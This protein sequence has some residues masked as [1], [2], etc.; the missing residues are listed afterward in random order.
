MLLQSPEQVHGAIMLSLIVSSILFGIITVQLILYVDHYADDKRTIKAVVTTSWLL[1]GLQVALIACSLYT[2]IPAPPG[3]PWVIIY[4]PWWA[5]QVWNTLSVYR[6]IGSRA[7]LLYLEDLSVES[8]D[9]CVGDPGH[10]DPA[11]TRHDPGP[12][13]IPMILLMDESVWVVILWLTTETTLD[14]L[15]A[16]FMTYSLIRERTGFSGTDAIICRMVHYALHTGLLTR[17][18]GSRRVS[19]PIDTSLERSSVCVASLISYGA[20]RWGGISVG[21]TL[22]LS[23]LYVTAMLAKYV[24]S[25]FSSLSDLTDELCSLHT[26]SSLRELS[27]N[28]EMTAE[29]ST[30]REGQQAQLYGDPALSFPTASASNSARVM[31]SRAQ[32]CVSLVQRQNVLC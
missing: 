4:V 23:G 10:P 27:E 32:V 7:K 24:S 21:L 19:S 11:E 6:D 1:Q 28:N 25:M 15:I 18:D 20:T 2:A 12:Y 13:W 9:A 16:V 14:L 26:R 17:F 3:N 5:Q 29:L 30:F 31:G 22:P 8:Q